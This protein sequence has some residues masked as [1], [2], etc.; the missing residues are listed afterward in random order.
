MTEST[1]QTANLSLVHRVRFPVERATRDGPHPAVIALHGRGS[2]EADLLGL[3]PYL[4]D[5]LLW[6]SARGP[7]DLEGGYEWYRLPNVGVP[8]QATYAAALGRIE[9]FIAEALAAYPID[10]ARLYLFGFSQGSMMAHSFTLLHPQRVRG[11]IAHSGYLPLKALEA[12]APFDPAGVRGKPYLIIH[13][14]RDPMIPAAWARQARDYLQAAGADV[15]Y[16]EFN[17]R[18]QVSDRSIAAVDGWLQR[19]LGEARHDR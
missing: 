2:D 19:Q 14:T 17:M 7:L 4:D 1:A 10:P 6:V 8:D 9:R 16:H 12:T 13:G 3:A 18:H 15:E 5:R 11:V